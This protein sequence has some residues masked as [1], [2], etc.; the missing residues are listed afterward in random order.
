MHAHNHITWPV[1]AMDSCFALLR[2]HEHGIASMVSLAIT[3][4]AFYCRGGLISTP[5]STSSTLN[6]VLLLVGNWKTVL[7]RHAYGD[8]IYEFAYI[9]QSE[10]VGIITME[11]SR[12]QILFLSDVFARSTSWYLY[13][14]IFIYFFSYNVLLFQLTHFVKCKHKKHRQ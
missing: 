3:D 4:L 10:Q 12:K 6:M 2:T 5:L 14:W 11:F 1:A 13:L 9:W 8:G 7:P